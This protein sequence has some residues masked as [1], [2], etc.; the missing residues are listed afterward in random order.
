M[1]PLNSEEEEKKEKERSVGEPLAKFWLFSLVSGTDT[2]L[3]KETKKR[4]ELSENPCTKFDLDVPLF[5]ISNFREILEKHQLISRIVSVGP[6][7]GI[8]KPWL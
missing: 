6:G 1:V 7:S 2:N 4:K 5:D 3:T 8:A